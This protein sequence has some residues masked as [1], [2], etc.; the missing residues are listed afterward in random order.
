MVAQ[1][2]STIRFLVSERNMPSMKIAIAATFTAEPLADALIFWSE[3]LGWKTDISFAPYNQVFQQL[4]DPTSLLSANTEGVNV[5]LIRPEDWQRYSTEPVPVE[6]SAAAEKLQSNAREFADAIR[7]AAK[8]S[9]TPYLVFLCPH[10]P[11]ASADPDVAAIEVTIASDLKGVQRVHLLNSADLA[12]Y[13]VSDG[14][15]ATGDKMGHVPY[16]SEL[17]AAMGTAI[18][19]K[20]HAL[21]QTPNKVIVV[22]CD[23]TLWKGVCGEVGPLGV[24]IDSGRRSFQEF[25]VRQHEAGMLLCLCSKNN[26]EDVDEVFAC[27]QDMPLKRG[28]IVA[29]R[30]NWRPKADNLRELASELNLGLDSFIFIDDNPLECEQVKASCPEILTLQLPRDSSSIPSFLQNLWAVDRQKVTE[31]DRKRTAFYRENRER[32]RFRD[33]A[34]TLEGFL[35]GLQLNVA[36]EPMTAEQLP[37]VSQLTQR[38]NQF[39]CTTLRR[40]ED[41]LGQL[42]SSG[43]SE[44]FTVTVSDRFGGYGLVGAMM[45]GA[46]PEALSVDNFLLSCR[47]LGRGVEHAMLRQLGDIARSRGLSRVDLQFIPS[48]KNRPAL[49]FLE[50][51]A[52]QYKQPAEAGYCFQIPAEFAARLSETQVLAT[53]QAAADAVRQQEQARPEK[54]AV[55]ARSDLMQEIATILTTAKAIGHAIDEQR[56][57]APPGRSQNTGGNRANI[58]QAIVDAWSKVLGSSEIGPD[59]DFFALGGDSLPAVQ[60]MMQLNQTFGTSLGL[61]DIFDNRTVAGLATAIEAALRL[62]EGIPVS[63]DVSASTSTTEAEMLATESRS[64]TQSAA[65]AAVPA[66]VRNAPERQPIQA[67]AGPGPYPLSFPQE[68]WWFLNQWAP[69]SPDLSSCVLRLKGTLNVAALQHA[70]SE[71]VARHDALRTIFQSTENGPVQIIRP[72]GDRCELPVLDLQGSGTEAESRAQQIIEEQESKPFDLTSDLMLRPTLLRLAND[73]HIL[74]LIAHHIAFDAWSREILLRDLETLYQAFLQEKPDPLPEVSNQYADYA[75]WQRNLVN[76]GALQGQLE[77]WKQRLAGIPTRLELPRTRSSSNAQVC[78]GER[79]STVLPAELTMALRALAQQEGVTFFMVLLAAFQTLL[80]RYSSQDDIVVGS[81]DAGRSHPQTEEVVGC[82]VNVLLFRTDFSGSPSF[83]ELLARVRESVLE[84]RNNQDVPLPKLVQELDPGRNMNQA[85]LFQAIFALEKALPVPQLPSLEVSVRELD[86]RTALHDISLFAME[87]PEGLRLKFECKTDSFDP[88]TIDRMVAHM[89]TLLQEIAA[90]PDCKVSTLPILAPAEE[91]QL[92]RGWNQFRHY[93]AKD[94]IHQLFEEQVRRA[95][96]RVALVFEGQEMSYGELNA[97]SNQ[98][99]GYLKRMGVGPEILVGLCVQRS[100]EMVIGIL[101]ILKAGGAYLPLDPSYPKDRLAFMVEDAKPPVVVTQYELKELFP[102]YAGRVVALDADWSE[103]E[104]EESLD[105]RCATTPQDLAYVIYTSGSTGRPKGCQVTHYNVVRLFEATQSWYCFDERDV[106]T[107]FHSYAFDFSVWELWG[108]LIYGGRLVV[109]PYLVSRSPEE[110]YRLLER[111]KVTVLN[112]TPSSFRQLI[113]AEELLGAADGISLRYVI[114]GGEALEIQSL[115]PWFDRHGD[116]KPQLI[117]MY[118]ITETTVHVTYRPLS[119]ADTAGGSVIGC[120]IPD[121]QVYLLDR[122]RQPVPVGV[123]GEMYVGGA[124]VARGYLNRPELTAERFIPDTFRREGQSRLYKTGDLARRLANGDIEYLGRIDQQ[125]KVRGFRIELGEIETVLTKHPAVRE[126]VV[127]VGDDEYGDKRLIAYL[128]PQNGLAPSN[129]EL[130]SF[131]KERLPEYMVPSAF[132]KLE[133][134]PLTSN[135]KVDRRALPEPELTRS[136]QQHEFVAPRTPLEEE[137]ASAWKQV[138]G[139]DQIGVHDNFF[140]IGGHSLLA[141]RVIILLRSNL[142]VN[143]SLRLLFENP[144]VATMAEVLV[145]TLLEHSDEPQLAE[146]INEVEA[147]SDETARQLRSSAS[148][149]TELAIDP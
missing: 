146:M 141:T 90:N 134:M 101:G 74:I 54:L 122:N 6:G 130:H 105:L 85:P 116:K 43:K 65:V 53:S 15:D 61:Q 16:T 11:K 100:L 49:T 99:A 135:G 93:P 127:I 131:L 126:S 118:G 37:R 79:R 103:V 39:N 109:V 40:T 26:A 80:H 70:L 106:W 57:V 104:R 75:V 139:L 31:E 111:E 35:A 52:G 125:V 82:F 77:Y 20:I 133:Q 68:S 107:M 119:L 137:V 112:Q 9:A 95:P 76:S 148:T 136:A 22:D 73:D 51:V 2:S 108:A 28:H 64:E 56:G 55:L 102:D 113:N 10:S 94:C 25:L 46:N 81:P 13:Q 7:N 147:L 17:F 24:Q 21:Q 120:P 92:T 83:R 42:W 50:S 89:S 32:E 72:R 5:L 12:P 114:F 67:Q 128:V 87:L 48:K 27:Q 123:P 18:S 97:R 78:R 88:E 62:K 63:S 143:L 140:E 45:F 91:E 96:E 66:N 144:T 138:L 71:F 1:A 98:L 69:G 124:G 30:V 33:E 117:N 145:E 23:D 149:D 142:G 47:V 4:L 36:I 60:V 8:R 14:Y 58:Q 44:C 110:F 38:T 86:T 129:A 59:D 115:K 34:P 132:V 3:K 19:R 84:A 121:L 29:Q 41:Q